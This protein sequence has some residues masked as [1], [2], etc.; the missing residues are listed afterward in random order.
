MCLCFCKSS[1]RE[2]HPSLEC[3]VRGGPP[4]HTLLLPFSTHVSSKVPCT[5]RMKR[6]I[7]LAAAHS[8]PLSLATVQ[9]TSNHK[10]LQWGDTRPGPGE[11][12]LLSLS[13]WSNSTRVK[14]I[15]WGHQIPDRS[16]CWSTFVDLGT[17][18]ELYNFLKSP[19]LPFYNL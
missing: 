4:A 16:H 6:L 2:R 11:S 8:Q 9:T 10:I 1:D 3:S 19:Y 13:M 7:C 5:Q 14:T 17:Q 12:S 18:F 15:I